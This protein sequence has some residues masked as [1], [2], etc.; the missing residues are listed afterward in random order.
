MSTDPTT[1]ILAAAILGA[2][3]GFIGASLMAAHQVRRANNDG[4]AEAVRHYQAEARRK[5]RD[6]S[7]L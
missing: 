6:A 3:I 5:Q 1:Y 2:S 4:Y 7:S